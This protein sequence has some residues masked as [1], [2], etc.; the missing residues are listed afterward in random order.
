MAWR[1]GEEC[2]LDQ[3]LSSNRELDSADRVA[4]LLVLRLVGWIFTSRDEQ[5]PVGSSEKIITASLLQRRKG[6]DIALE[7]FHMS[8]Q[9]VQSTSDSLF[10]LPAPASNASLIATTEPVSVEGRETT[11]LDVL[12]YLI[13]VAIQS[14]EGWLQNSFPSPFVP[15]LNGE[16]SL[17][18]VMRRHVLGRGVKRRPLSAQPLALCCQV[19][20]QGSG[21]AGVVSCCASCA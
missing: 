3:L 2:D 6:N 1:E 15:Q 19:C 5:T 18:A 4:E 11:D 14:H 21:F 9:A 16:E 17:A 10:V 12:F 13:P 7:A 8:K 20:Q